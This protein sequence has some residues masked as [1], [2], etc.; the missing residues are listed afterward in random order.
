MAPNGS[1][2][3]YLTHIAEH[4]QASGTI[5]VDKHFKEDIRLG[6]ALVRQCRAD[7]IDGSSKESGAD[8]LLQDL[9]VQ[10]IPVFRHRRGCRGVR[11]GCGIRRSGG[12]RCRRG[13]VIGDHDHIHT[14]CGIRRGRLLA[15]GSQCQQNTSHQK[16]RN[17]SLHK[18]YILSYFSGSSAF[19]CIIPD[20]PGECNPQIIPS[21]H[22]PWFSQENSRIHCPGRE[23]DLSPGPG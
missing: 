11:C 5:V 9:T 17:K 15:A 19:C 3:R 18:Q 8:R 2:I 6:N 14:G 20:F 13:V 4:S 16:Q 1:N 7:I 12:I 22:L 10:R 23:K 21:A